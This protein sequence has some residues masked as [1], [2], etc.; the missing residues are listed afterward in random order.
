M[1]V[2]FIY[3]LINSVNMEQ[4]IIQHYLSRIVK[5]T[6]VCGDYTNPFS[7]LNYYFESENKTEVAKAKVAGTI[8]KDPI[9]KYEDRY[10]SS[11]YGQVVNPQNQDSWLK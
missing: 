10:P 7:P 6:G 4:N 1:I 9:Q 5:M 3:L 2:S 11:E 8:K